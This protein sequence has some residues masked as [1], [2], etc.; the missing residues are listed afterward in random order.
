MSIS[1]DHTFAASSV[2]VGILDTHLLVG[3]TIGSTILSTT[4]ATASDVAVV[5]ANLPDNI[6]ECVLDVD[7]GLGG[8]FDEAAAEITS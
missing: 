4:C 6:V 5:F 7:T 3:T 2:R 8:G 1:H